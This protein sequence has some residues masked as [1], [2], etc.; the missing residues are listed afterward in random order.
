MSRKTTK[1]LIKDFVSN[2]FKDHE[3]AQN[4]LIEQIKNNQLTGTF[5]P[6]HVEHVQRTESLIKALDYTPEFIESDDFNE[7]SDEKIK[8][9]AKHSYESV[10]RRENDYLRGGISSKDIYVL[11]GVAQYRAFLEKLV[12]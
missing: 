5:G 11:S 2:A 9:W 8:E 1:Q 12:K 7:T 3:K 6:S 4:E 10:K